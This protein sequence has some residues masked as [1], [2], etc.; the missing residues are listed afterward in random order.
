MVKDQIVELIKKI[1][2]IVQIDSI[3]SDFS[4]FSSIKFFIYLVLTISIIL[5]SY[6]TF[7]IVIYL[8]SFLIK[9]H[10]NSEFNSQMIINIILLLLTSYITYICFKILRH[11]KLK[12]LF[13]IFKYMLNKRNEI[14]IEIEYFN[15]T[16]LFPFDMKAV[17][18]QTF[19]YI[20][21]L[22]DMNT[23]YEMEKHTFNNTR[24]ESDVI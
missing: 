24:N 21:I 20:Q 9:T 2:S 1:N 5:M 3:S 14:R 13:E 12:Q 16:V 22:Y 6:F 7:L 17:L 19:D 4:K 15:N 10:K 11:F 8:I 18:S 23:N